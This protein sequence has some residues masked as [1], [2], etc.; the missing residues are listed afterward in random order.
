MR[1]VAP[2]LFLLQILEKSLIKLLTYTPMTGI[3]NT[4]RR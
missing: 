2:S 4:E 1:G 3:I